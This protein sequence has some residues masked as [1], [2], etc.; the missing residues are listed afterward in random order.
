[1]SRTTISPTSPV[2]DEDGNQGAEQYYED[3]LTNHYR[4][5]GGRFTM[6]VN[7]STRPL[8]VGRYGREAQAPPQ[9][10]LTL[11]NPPGVPAEGDSE[12]TTFEVEGLPEADNGFATV[13]IGWPPSNDPEEHDWDFYVVGPNGEAVGSGATLD[14][15][16][17][18]KIPDP[19]EGTYT[20]EA[21]N[22]QG[23]DADHDWSGTVTFQS[24]VPP[25]Y[26]GIKE[27]WQFSCTNRRGDI[28]AS[29]K[30]V[31]DRGEAVDVGK[32]CEPRKRG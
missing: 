5:D 25:Q 13:T 16:E 30:V 10:G 11:V 31:V 18:I 29:R 32:A 21:N 1:M 4:S 20:I 14:N 22:Y 9:H 7:P 15:P 24:P 17:V 8:V 23:G 27:A 26:S 6:D 2:Q 3:T 19:V 28:L 12:E